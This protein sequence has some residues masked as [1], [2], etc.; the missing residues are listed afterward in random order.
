[1]LEKISFFWY[2]KKIGWLAFLGFGAGAG[3]YLLIKA[4]L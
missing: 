4:M 2:F 1:M 3:V